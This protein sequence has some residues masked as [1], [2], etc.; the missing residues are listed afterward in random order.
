[1]PH[2]PSKVTNRDFLEAAFKYMR[3]GEFAA[4]CNFAGCPI[5]Q[6]RSS[7]VSRPWRQGQHVPGSFMGVPQNVY[8]VVSSFKVADDGTFHRRKAEFCQMHVLMVD[9]VFEKVPRDKL[10]LVPSA[11]IQTSPKSWQ[12]YY[13]LESAPETRN[14]DY[15]GRVL[16]AMVRSGL[17]SDNKDPGMRGIT[18]YGRLPVGVN[19]KKKYGPVPFKCK[20]DVWQPQRRYTLE[21]LVKSFKLDLS[22]VPS[23]AY[24]AS[25]FKLRRGEASKRVRDFEE[26][27]KALSDAGLYMASRGAWH[28][29]VCP[30]ISEHSDQKPGGSALYNPAEGNSWLGGYKCWH[31]HCEGRTVGDVYKFVHLMRRGAA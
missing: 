14:G 10:K 22:A 12:A 21:R 3:E 31:G 13:F 9:D 25:K 24:N 16:D 5:E 2:D 4:V 15:C 26:M 17:T 27:L 7:W 23:G 11:M 6:P 30:W 20:L 1:L 28:D 18:R 29:I 8:A 19:A